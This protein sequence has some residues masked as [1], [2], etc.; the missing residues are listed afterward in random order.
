MNSI[1]FVLNED[2]SARGV[3]FYAKMLGLELWNVEMIKSMSN[4]IFFLKKQCR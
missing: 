4:S 1:S 3:N 2:L